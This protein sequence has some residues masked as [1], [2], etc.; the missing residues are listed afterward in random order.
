MS[1]FSTTILAVGPNAS[2]ELGDTTPPYTPFPF[3]GSHIP[4]TNPNVISVHFPN[5][6]SNPSMVGWNNPAGRQ[7][8]SYF[9]TFSVSILTNTFVLMNRLQSFRFPPRGFH[10]YT[11]GTP[12]PRSNLVSGI[13]HNPQPRSNPAGGNFH[14]P[15]QTIPPRMMP[16]PPYMNHLGGGPYNSG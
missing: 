9:P 3:G 1:Q 13:F 10:Y 16:N 2:L 5:H 7:V 12:Q 14:N 8:L 6:G 15:Y 4:Q 11:L